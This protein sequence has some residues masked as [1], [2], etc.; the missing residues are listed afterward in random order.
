MGATTRPMT[1]EELFELPDDGQRHELVAG[2]ILDMTPTFYDRSFIVGA[3]FKQIVLLTAGKIPGN[4]TV[5]SSF[6]I[7]RNPD[8]VRIPD[9]ALVTQERIN[10]SGIPRTFYAGAP[11]LAV[12]VISPSERAAE[13]EAKITEYLLAG[14]QIVWVVQPMTRTVTV[15]VPN[16]SPRLL[17]VNDTLDAG[18]LIPE[19]ALPVR[20]ILSAV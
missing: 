14:T 18:D 5:E 10:A 2:E 3:I 6:L 16:Q 13:I 7:A 9:I 1:A 17:T 11:D 12:E 20:D 19:L 15:H 4:L 8:T